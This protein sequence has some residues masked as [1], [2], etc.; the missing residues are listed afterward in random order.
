DV[1][2]NTTNDSSFLALHNNATHELLVD[3]DSTTDISSS[4]LKASNKYFNVTLDGS[5]DQ[6]Q[7]I[8]DNF[9]DH[10]FDLKLDPTNLVSQYQLKSGA[11]ELL[12]EAFEYGNTYVG[13]NQTAYILQHTD[14]VDNTI[15]TA[16]RTRFS[17]HVDTLIDAEVDITG[18]THIN[19]DLAVDGN[20]HSVG[21]LSTDDNLYVL[22]K[23]YIDG[24]TH[25]G[26]GSTGGSPGS[27]PSHPPTGSDLTAPLLSVYSLSHFHNDVVFEDDT[28]VTIDANTIVNGETTVNGNT[29]FVG[30]VTANGNNVI[31]GETTINGET[32]VNGN[33]T[34]NG[35]VEITNEEFHINEMHWDDGAV[36]VLLVQEG[37]WHTPLQMQANNSHWNGDAIFSYPSNTAI[38]TTQPSIATPYHSNGNGLTALKEATWL[39]TNIDLHDTVGIRTHSDGTYFWDVHQNFYVPP[40]AIMAFAMTGNPDGWIYCDG[41]ELD[42]LIYAGLYNAIGTTWGA[43]TDGAGLVGTTHFRVPDLRGAFLRGTGSKSINARTKTGQSV[44]SFAEDQMQKITGSFKTSSSKGFLYD[45]SE[46]SSTVSG[47]LKG[48]YEGYASSGYAQGAQAY[49]NGF[50]FNSSNSPDARTSSTTDGETYPY[51]AAV[52]YYIKY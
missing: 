14:P 10:L 34:F 32:A 2:L 39:S 6:S 42:L 26:P 15:Y 5:L 35:T 40:G 48:I 18:N 7:L 50:S 11:T 49:L 4:N 31:N 51:N 27:M 25:I 37:K 29:L 13:F 45:Y 16:E 33:T 22:G 1:N 41:S 9:A 20:T 19:G 23:T 36:D 43:L 21:M 52:K 44:G 24:N 47:A 12:V 46:T 30:D 3:L 17:I 8:L 28:L 38:L